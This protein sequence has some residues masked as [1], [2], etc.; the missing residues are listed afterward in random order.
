MCFGKEKLECVS[1]VVF[2]M[3]N[4][5]QDRPPWSFAD[6]ER[7]LWPAVADVINALFL[8]QTERSLTAEQ[9]GYLAERLLG[10]VTLLMLKWSNS[11][12]GSF[13]CKC[14]SRVLWPH[15]AGI[16]GRPALRVTYV[17][18]VVCSP[19][20]ISL[21]WDSRPRHQLIT[22]HRTCAAFTLSGRVLVGC[23]GEAW[24]G[25]EGDDGVE[26][27]IFEGECFQLKP[28]I[29]GNNVEGYVQWRTRGCRGSWICT[30]AIIPYFLG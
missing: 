18:V 29:E 9:L 6:E 22:W 10:A 1:S 13:F 12:H 5:C 8:R 26:G 3:W 20:P 28:S 17:R 30:D 11:L 15:H 21:T 24:N 25:H 2:D 7:I 16:R 27:Q 19:N 4:I 14:T 23:R